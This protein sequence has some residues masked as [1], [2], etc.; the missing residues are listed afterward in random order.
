MADH[1]VRNSSHV[2][3]VGA[4]WGGG[5]TPISSH[6]SLTI[7]LLNG[8]S[9]QFIVFN[10]FLEVYSSFNPVEEGWQSKNRKVPV[11]VIQDVT[12]QLIKINTPKGVGLN[13]DWENQFSQRF[14]TIRR[15]K[16]CKWVAIKHALVYT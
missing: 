12:P 8:K 2:T 1:I 10:I 6:Y 14:L 3:S 9:L 4:G 5:N 16:M 15:K 11:A 7:Q 13:N